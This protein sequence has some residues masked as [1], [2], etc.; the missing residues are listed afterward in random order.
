MARSTNVLLPVVGAVL[1]LIGGVSAPAQARKPSPAPVVSPAEQAQLREVARRGALLYAYDQAAWQG[2]DDMVAKMPDYAT[3]VGGWIVDGPAEALELV[4]FDRDQSN[5]H[6]VFVARFAAGKLVS[7]RVVG[8]GESGL[9]PERRQLVAAREAALEAMD[10]ANLPRCVEAPM[11]SV[12]L[13]P[14]APGEPTLV[15]I[16]TPQRVTNALPFGGHYLIPVDATGTAGEIRH[17]AKS[18]LELPLPSA[19]ERPQVVSLGVTHLL[20]PLPT[21]IHVFSSLA[22]HMPVTVGTSDGRAWWVDG[23][24]IRLLGKAGKR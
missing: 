2:T 1:A 24:A 21:E 16:L 22:A 3:R 15:Y 4:F 7:G 10:A 19:T 11:N 5:P 12:V 20:D 13:P 9:S 6:A 18:C 17:F 23:T 8:A 14:A